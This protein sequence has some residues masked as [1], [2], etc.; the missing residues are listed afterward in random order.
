VSRD[1][2]GR[3][4]INGTVNIASLVAGLVCCGLAL[5]WLLV[6]VRAIAVSDLGWLLPVVLVGAGVIGVGLS[7]QRSR[8]RTR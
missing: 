6:Q 2:S 4:P 7:L 8:R 3:R 1:R 5:G